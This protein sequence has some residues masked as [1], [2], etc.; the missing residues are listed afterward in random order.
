MEAMR[1]AYKMSVGET[2]EN[3]LTSLHANRSHAVNELDIKSN[4]NKDLRR[5]SLIVQ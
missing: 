2:E 1:N 4:K 5:E 3:I